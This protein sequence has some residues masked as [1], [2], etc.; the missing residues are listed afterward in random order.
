MAHARDGRPRDL[1]P[2]A[3]KIPPSLT[4]RQAQ[5][6]ALLRSGY[7]R[8]RPFTLREMCEAMGIRSTNGINDHLRALERKGLVRQGSGQSR[9]AWVPV[10]DRSDPPPGIRL[11]TTRDPPGVRA[12]FEDDGDLVAYGPSREVAIER[13]WAARDRDL[14]RW[15]ISVS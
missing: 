7:A 13:A 10:E 11:V 5:A 3:V 9:L 12:V 2:Q 8:G 4:H 14:A 15:R 6:L 1:G